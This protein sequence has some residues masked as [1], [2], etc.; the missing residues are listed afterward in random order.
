MKL[1]AILT[2]V[3]ATLVAGDGA[4]RD[5][6]EEIQARQSY[7]GQGCTNTLVSETHR[8]SFVTHEEPSVILFVCVTHEMGRNANIITRGTTSTITYGEHANTPARAPAA[9]G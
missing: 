9:E 6:E 4:R 5:A 7:I 3:V 1:I 2:G 8:E